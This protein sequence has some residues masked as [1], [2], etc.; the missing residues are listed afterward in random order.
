MEKWLDTTCPYCGVGCGVRGT[1]RADQL[2]SVTGDPAHPANLGK[3]CIKGSSLHETLGDHGRLLHPQV[4]GKQV[5]W[6]T[7]IAEVASR[8]QRTRDRYGPQ[9]IAFYLSGQLLTED[10]YVANKLAK[11]FLGTGHVDTN[12]RLCMSSAVAAHK[13]AFGADLVPCSYEDLES[14]DLLVLTGSN[15]AWTHPILYQRMVAAKARN[16]ALRVV[17]ID[18]RRTATCDIADLHLQITPGTDGLLFSGLLAWL[19]RNGAT[20]PAF[21][22]HHTRQFAEA[23]SNVRSLTTAGVAESCGID[24]ASLQRFFQWYAKTPRTVTFF[25]QGINQSTRGTD[26]GNAIIN[27]HLATG[28]IGQPGAGPFSIT[29]QPNAMGGREVGGLSNVLAAHMEYTE[30]HRALVGEF[31][32]TASVSREAGLKAIDLFHAVH[33]GDIRAIWIMGTNPVVSMP[34]ADAVRAALQAC[35]SVIVSDCIAE[36]D[37]T[38]CADILLPARGWAEKSGTVTNSERRISRQRALI[39][40][41]GEA[42]ADWLIVTQVAHALGHA[43]AFPYQSPRDIFVEHAALSGFRNDGTRFFDISALSALDESAYDSLQPVQWPVRDD[44]PAGTPRLFTDGVFNTRD[45]RACFVPTQP[46]VAVQGPMRKFPLILNTGRERDQWHT[47]TRTGRTQRLLSHMEAPTVRLHPAT[48]RTRGIS[49]GDVVEISSTRGSAHMLARIDAGQ[50]PDALFA[51]IHWN[52]QFAGNARIGALIAPR[53]DPVSGQPELKCTPVEIRKLNISGW[54]VLAS[55]PPLQMAAFSFWCVIRQAGMDARVYLVALGADFDWHDW[56]P[57]QGLSH[58]SVF[59][60]HDPSD[61]FNYRHIGVSQEQVELAIFSAVQRDRLP[62]LDWMATLFEGGSNGPG[63]KSLAGPS[64]AEQAS[65]RRICSCHQVGETQIIT[66]IHAGANTVE[67][68]GR[69]LLCGTNCGSCIPELKLLI[70][71]NEQAG[72]A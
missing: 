43:E 32:Q 56:L 47:M 23:L 63:L 7:A 57:E 52:D 1:I 29:G 3:L 24:T 18:P 17:V 22:Q 44:C 31:W 49:D 53:V 71:Q 67:S 11:G 15:A 27:C 48:A 55:R 51:P 37:T 12:S 38:A 41:P 69:Q 28:R 34:D 72:A 60:R 35:D 13:R 16:P 21:I 4:R 6:D 46:E 9:S 64:A 70:S 5:D 58:D 59:C 68:L 26:Q 66:A 54:A 62:S 25:S 30:A 50:Q 40:A 19:E 10:Y 36:T 45:G 42:R 33:R 61:A 20:N 65:G 2:I 8:L 14:A 39:E